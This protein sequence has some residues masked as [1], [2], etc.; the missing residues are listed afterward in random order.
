MISCKK[1]DPWFAILTLFFIY[2]TCVNVIATLYGPKKAGMVGFVAGCV[3]LIVGGILGYIGYSLPSPV[4]AI[5]GWF[6]IILG[7]GVA[8]LGL[9]LCWFVFGFSRPSVIHFCLFIPLMILS[10]AIF[11]F[12]KLL[13]IFEAENTF[14]QSQSTYMSRGEAILEAAP[15]LCLQVSAAMITMDPSRQ[16]LFSIITSVAT[17][18]LP[19]IESYVTARGGEFGF[20]SI[21]KNIAVFLPA[22]LFKV[23][24]FSIICVFFRAYEFGFVI[25]FTALYWLLLLYFRV[26][27]YNVMRGFMK[28][29]FVVLHWLTLGSLGASKM[30]AVFRSWF[31]LLVTIIYT[32][33]LSA[34][35]VVCYVD[36]DKGSVQLPVLGME[37]TWSDLEMVKHPF[38]L[39][40]ILYSTISLGWITLFLDILSAWCRLKDSFDDETELLDRTVLLGGLK[41]NLKEI[42]TLN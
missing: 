18:S 33:I 14:V 36:P 11:I 7:D 22:S 13:A 32:I 37:F 3:M 28:S 17:L 30:D 35:L 15:Q 1:N 39:N 10:P 41:F 38:F 8:G 27:H 24:S 16:Q 4:A 9:C 6:M 19:N 2:L 34:I 21:I 31:T 12:I 25:G 23:L 40:L 29:E 20:D 5:M 26:C 42:N